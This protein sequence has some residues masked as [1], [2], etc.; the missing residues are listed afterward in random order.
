M[1]V[2]GVALME[3]CDACGYA[4]NRQVAQVRKPAPSPE[5][6][7]LLERVA[8]PGTST[9]DDLAA[10]LGVPTSRTAKAVFFVATVAD[11]ADA[12]AMR[13]QFVFAVVRGDTDLNETQLANALA[14]REL[15]PAHDDE[16]R[17]V[18]AEPGYASP[19]GLSQENILVI[20]DDLIPQCPN[21]VAGANAVG[22]HLRHTN[23]GRDYR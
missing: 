15:R 11:P 10:Y 19:I 18:G 2:V 14:A 17:P 9:I 5:A 1:S 8:T 6:P 12:N 3:M 16:I 13:K 22:Y 21:L 23:Y 20:V 7:L 4:A